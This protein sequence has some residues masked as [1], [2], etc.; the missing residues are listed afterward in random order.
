M[1]LKTQALIMDNK[2]NGSSSKYFVG[3]MLLSLSL[4]PQNFKHFQ[5]PI[6]VI[7]SCVNNHCGLDLHM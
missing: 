6:K 5:V 2:I 4:T 3:F 7:I 1:S